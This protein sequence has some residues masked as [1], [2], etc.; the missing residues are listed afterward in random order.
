MFSSTMPW[1]AGI[2]LLCLSACSAQTLEPHSPPTP[3][4]PTQKVT[5]YD[6]DGDLIPDTTIT[7][8]YLDQKVVR[9]GWDMDQD[10]KEDRI[11]HRTYDRNG[12]CIRKEIDRDADGI[13]D[14]ITYLR[15]SS[16]GKLEFQGFDADNDGTL[17]WIR[18]LP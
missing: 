3:V 12:N 1:K 9:K 16:E 2:F 5:R 10:G 18:K 13:V 8:A 15:F 17:D 11:E 4:E 7:W 6:R 14:A